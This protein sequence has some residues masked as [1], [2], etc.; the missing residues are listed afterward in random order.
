MGGRRETHRKDDKDTTTVVESERQEPPVRLFRVGVKSKKVTRLSTNR[1]RI[2]HLSV[3]PDGKR[4]VTGHSPG[5]TPR[6]TNVVDS[7]ASLRSSGPRTKPPTVSA[8][9]AYARVPSVRT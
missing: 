1:D 4:A 5:G 7:F 2:E 6:K 9:L 3:S 8:T